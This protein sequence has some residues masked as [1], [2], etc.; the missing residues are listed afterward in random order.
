MLGSDI[1]PTPFLVRLGFTALNRTLAFRLGQLLG[2]LRENVIIFQRVCVILHDVPPD[3]PVAVRDSIDDHSCP[4]Y[5]IAGTELNAIP[6]LEAR[7]LRN[8]CL[9]LRGRLLYRLPTL[10]PRDPD[11]NLIDSQPL[12][13]ECAVASFLLDYLSCVGIATQRDRFKILALTHRLFQLGDALLIYELA[14]SR[15]EILSRRHLHYRFGPCFPTLPPGN[16]DSFPLA[17]R[18]PFRLRWRSRLARHIR[19]ARNRILGLCGRQEILVHYHVPPAL[20]DAHPALAPA[21]LGIWLWMRRRHSSPLAPLA[22]VFVIA[23]FVFLLAQKRMWAFYFDPLIPAC[24]ALGAYPWV[25]LR[26]RPVAPRW[27]WAPP[28]LLAA[29]LAVPLYASVRDYLAH[30]SHYLM[31]VQ[32]M[33]EYLAQ[34]APEGAALFGDS[35]S[36]PL[37]ALLTGLPVAG[38]EVD[39]N[40]M[41]FTSGTSPLG[42]VLDSLRAYPVTYVVGNSYVA[43][44]GSG[45]VWMGVAGLPE[46]RRLV[47]GA[48]FREFHDPRKGTYVIY[49]LSRVPR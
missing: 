40:V 35:A 39:T 2:V 5:P 12:S 6:L 30:E 42:S 33:A 37:L 49:E 48:P 32:P 14:P 46:F 34:R 21:A 26:A 3:S 8:D 18:R 10:P 9:L 19:P 23:H 38:N 27:K 20:G 43:R 31:A 41:R 25:V 11:R 7:G 29:L 47:A 28:V 1:A 24:A 16:P 22:G 15:I 17:L 36:T 45:R 44:G 13:S 4:R